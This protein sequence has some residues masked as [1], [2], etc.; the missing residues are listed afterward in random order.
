MFFKK[1][2]LEA[3]ATTGNLRRRFHH[4]LISKR[5][6]NSKKY[7][8]ARPKRLLKT[9]QKLSPAAIILRKLAF[10]VIALGIAAG[11]VYV[12]FFSSF[13]DITK[14]T[15]DKN[16]NAVA[17]SALTPFIDKIKDKN[18]LFVK[19]STLAKEIEQTFKNEIL[20]VKIQKSYPHKIIIK[21][22]EYPAVLNLTVLTPEKNQKFV[23][24]QTGYSILENIEQKD[25]PLLILRT[26]KPFS[27]GK[28]IIIERQKLN[29]IVESYQK[30]T[31][32][33]GLKI[34][35][36][37]WKKTEREL[38]LKTEKNFTVWIDLTADIS[39][40]ISKLKRAMP[41]LDIYN[42]KLEYIDLRISGGDNEKVIFKR[43]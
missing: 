23:L 35:S 7:A 13:F 41:K 40:Q 12:M 29:P 11:A 36:G 17:G 37:E 20:L 27:E 38:H 25:I 16:G 3:E 42:E 14:V 43:R 30:F 1:K 8:F 6:E 32:T 18:L 19:T 28:K 4:L 21:I 22:E 9:Q 24:N 2:S 39:Q 5:K 15:I 10:F 33:T 34:T 31:E 26:S